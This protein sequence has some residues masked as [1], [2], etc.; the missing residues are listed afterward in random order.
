MTDTQ[1]HLDL[2]KEKKK[3][4]IIIG[5]VIIA[6][7]GTVWWWRIYV[8]PYESTDD[9]SI[10]GI[11]ISV[12]PEQ[13]G[14]IVQLLV[15]EGD[16]VKTG[17][18]LFILDDQVLQAQREEV[19]AMVAKAND[20][21]NLQKVKTEL[22]W[23]DFRRAK[24]EYEDA[25]ISPEAM[26]HATKELEAQRAQLQAM[27]SQVVVQEAHLKMIETQISK[28]AIYASCDGVIGKRWHFPGD[29][30]SQ[31]QTVFTLFDLKDVWIT[32]NLEETKVAAVHFND[33]VKIRV[34]AYPRLEFEGNV[35]IIG[36]GAAS[37][38]SLIPPNNASG[39][40]TKVTQRV[41]IRISLKP[42]YSGDTLY[43]R[44]GMS[45]EIK[46]KSR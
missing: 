42:P 5:L 28:C 36:A 38:F 6:L 3:I 29:V 35:E 26:D 25:V 37:Q 20:D 39:N 21:V 8:Y 31:G 40:F 14:R 13:S 10:D 27:Y 4:Y 16:H 2:F 43:L 9:A 1:A 34:D 12:S 15:D 23:Q 22:A 46:I 41:P 45:V 18:L 44:P 33:L 32:A 17:D 11:E 30:V 24:R 19:R 7:I